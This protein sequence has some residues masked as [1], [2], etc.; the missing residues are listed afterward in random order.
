MPGHFLVSFDK[1]LNEITLSFKNGSLHQ[2]LE[3]KCQV[4]KKYCYFVFQGHAA[5][6]MDIFE[7]RPNGT[8]IH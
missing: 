3:E 7:P 8:R 4:D 2:I 1:S 5:A 6:H